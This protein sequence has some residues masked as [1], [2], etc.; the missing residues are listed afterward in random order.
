MLLDGI[1]TLFDVLWAQLVNVPTDSFLSV[2]YVILNAI[3]LL[4]APFVG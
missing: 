4:F 1:V 2:V 3:L